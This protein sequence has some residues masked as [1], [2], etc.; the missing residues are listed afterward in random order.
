MDAYREESRAIMQLVAQT[1][2]VVEQMSVDEVYLDLSAGCQGVDADASLRL[3][4]PI[5][6][7]LKQRIAVA[8]KG[9]GYII[10]SANSL[11]DYCKIDNV[12][13]MAKA[14]QKY[15]KY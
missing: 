13:A 15:G 9:G 10:S 6:Q 14:L 5:A 4:L 3:A 2:A 11:T 8:G 7:E 1:G 12:W